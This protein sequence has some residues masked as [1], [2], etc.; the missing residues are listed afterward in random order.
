MR[1][2]GKKKLVVKDKAKEREGSGRGR[3]G[4]RMGKKYQLL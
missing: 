3:G 4:N 1:R 2:D